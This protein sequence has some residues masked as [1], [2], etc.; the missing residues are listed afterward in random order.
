MLCRYFGIQSPSKTGGTGKAHIAKIRAVSPYLRSSKI[1]CHLI[2]RHNKQDLYLWNQL[3]TSS[4][5]QE[6]VAFALVD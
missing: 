3:I 4:E 1:V 2:I 6:F 5:N